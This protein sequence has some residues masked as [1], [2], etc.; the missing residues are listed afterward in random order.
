MRRGRSFTSW[1]IVTLLFVAPAGGG[2]QLA[3]GVQVVTPQ[4]PLGQVLFG[5]CAGDEA[6]LRAGPRTRTLEIISVT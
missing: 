6:E 3:G 5:K 1:L 4:S 2:N